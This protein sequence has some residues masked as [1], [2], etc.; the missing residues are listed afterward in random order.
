MLNHIVRRLGGLPLMGIILLALSS[1]FFLA[2]LSGPVHAQSS[3]LQIALIGPTRL[4]SDLTETWQVYITNNNDFDVNNI[5]LRLRYDYPGLLDDL[6]WQSGFGGNAY[7]DPISL[8]ARTAMLIDVTMRGAPGVTRTQSIIMQTCADSDDIEVAGCYGYHVNVLPPGPRVMVNA[9]LAPNQTYTTFAGQILHT[10]VSLTNRGSATAITG[11]VLVYPPQ[12]IRVKQLSNQHWET[13][14]QGMALSYPGVIMV[15]QTLTDV[16]HFQVDEFPPFGE[17]N[18]E[19]CTV[20]IAPP[21]GSNQEERTCDPDG[22]SYQIV[23]TPPMPAVQIQSTAML[24]PSADCTLGSNPFI[25][26]LGQVFTNCNVLTAYGAASENMK[27]DVF[28]G[29]QLV[30]TIETLEP[31]RFTNVNTNLVYNAAITSTTVTAVATGLS[32][33]LTATATATLYLTPTGQVELLPLI[34]SLR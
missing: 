12:G 24:G 1:A 28:V 20:A 7:Y 23:V 33:N 29:G 25:Y 10:I 2:M 8:T 19:I 5:D 6:D 9:D 13:V 11:Q 32:S 34:L 26:Q 16:I 30:R 17:A 21:G 15:G 22:V 4:T 31:G 18:V 3:S 27:V 14:P